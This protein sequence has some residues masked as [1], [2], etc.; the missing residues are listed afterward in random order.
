MS[1][2][3]R[4]RFVWYDLMTKDQEK[5]IDF[6]SE[7]VGWKTEDWPNAP[8]RY[9]MWKPAT[10]KTIGG[11]VQLPAD[12]QVPQHWIGYIAMP[13]V[14]DSIA[15][16]T[17]LGATVVSPPQDIPTVGRSAVLADPQGAVFAIFTPEGDAPGHEGEPE[18]GEVSWHELYTTDYKAAFD[19]YSQLFG[20]EKSR[21]MDMG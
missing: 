15:A 20:W 7:V 10:G 5:A 1:T 8:T 12:Q 4:G 18:V 19:F 3:P 11:S 16:A 13:N 21:E 14:D 6:Y 9:A 2:V 17:K